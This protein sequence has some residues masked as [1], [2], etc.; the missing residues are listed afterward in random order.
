MGVRAGLNGAVA[1]VVVSL[2]VAFAQP[3]AH[4]ANNAL[5]AASSLSTWK[6]IGPQGGFV[7]SVAVDST[8][9]S[10]VYIG[11]NDG[12]VFKSTDS[13][14]TWVSSGLQGVEIRALAV[15]P[16]DDNVVYAGSPF[17]LYTTTDGGKT[18]TYNNPLGS[19]QINAMAVD[20]SDGSTVFVAS[21]SGGV[22]QTS[23]SG[24][25]WTNTNDGLTAGQINDL[26]EAPSSPATLYAAT[27]SGVF[28]STNSGG[29][30]SAANAGLTDTNI[31]SV[32]V[33]PANASSA[34]A[35]TSPSEFVLSG[36]HSTTGGSSW[37]SD[38]SGLPGPPSE[39]FGL[40]NVPLLVTSTSVYAGIPGSGLFAE[41]KTSTT[42]AAA[43]AGMTDPDGLATQRVF[44]LAADPANDSD[45]YA[46]SRDGGMFAST[47]AGSTWMA[48]DTGLLGNGVFA[49]AG[50][51]SNQNLIY[52]GTA[53]LGL[54]VSSD[55][56]K[57]WTAAAGVAGALIN[58]I[59]FDPSRAATVW[60]GGAGIYKT[61]DNGL[62]WAGSVGGQAGLPLPTSVT[63]IAIDPLNAKIV[64]ITLLGKGVYE[65]TNGGTSWK[66]VSTGLSD[67]NDLAIAAD[68]STAG[69]LYVGT[70]SSGVFTSTDGGTSWTQMATTGLPSLEVLS[71]A[72]ATGTLE[73]GTE[74]GSAY[75]APTAAAG[76]FSPLAGAFDDSK[77]YNNA[78]PPQQITVHSVKMKY[79]G[80]GS[81]GA[82]PTVYTVW[83]ANANEGTFMSYDSGKT[84]FQVPTKAP[85]PVENAAASSFGGD[86][87]WLVGTFGNGIYAL[88][89]K[90]PVFSSSASRTTSSGPATAIVPPRETRGTTGSVSV[91]GSSGMGKVTVE[92]YFA[93]PSHAKTPSATD[94]F[95]GT[96]VASTSTFQ[97]VAVDDCQLTDDS[98][99]VY[100]LDG[101][102]WLAASDQSYD[103][104]TG[105]VTIT[106]NDAT[107]P[108]LTNLK[109]AFFANI[110]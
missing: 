9:P 43:G 107:V 67:L 26:V 80:F 69:L 20:P 17:G 58:D 85:A 81:I 64:W 110:G 100:W 72:D 52:A 47:D 73:V 42:W 36:Y 6:N 63:G 75:F 95:F 104:A 105:C 90:A 88:P 91:T 102:S 34:W 109:G 1:V 35:I 66:A 27:P 24:S 92:D 19:V 93:D 79:K 48:A 39:R 31:Q 29:S 77:F 55:G 49:L 76:R 108:G 59:T 12:G 101:S 28:V 37:A 60:A 14:S 57:T 8:M 11:I 94:S 4:A 51:P 15:D 23:D 32:A 21:Q 2:A 16:A 13:A 68:P 56:G 106:L 38:S 99:T 25:T 61:T 103:P 45:L 78:K 18:W 46:G 22:Y 53:N 96:F 10:T 44:A 65:T 70:E 98:T 82:T 83:Q 87:L 54:F 40:E 30:W 86:P 5:A 62:Q 74:A 41:S 3:P 89:S 7:E 97:S 50:N 71:V 33:D 84:F